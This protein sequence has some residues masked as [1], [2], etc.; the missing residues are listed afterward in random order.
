MARSAL[1]LETNVRYNAG[2]RIKKTPGLGDDLTPREC[3]VV[4]KLCADKTIKELHTEMGISR[5]TF[6]EH[7]TAALLKTGKRTRTGLVR[8]AISREGGI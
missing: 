3:D 5:R 1:L 8:Y 2:M 4:S 6:N 7:M